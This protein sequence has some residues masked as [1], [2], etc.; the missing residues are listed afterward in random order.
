TFGKLLTPEEIFYYIYAVLY[1]NVY[2]TKYAEFL[3]IDFPRIPFTSDYDIFA[4]MS[5]LGKRLTDLHLLKSPELDS[6]VAKFQGSG[7]SE[8]V[9]V[10]FVEN[11]NRVYI[12]ETQYFEGISKEVFEYQIGGYEV[13]SKWLKDRKGRYLTLDETIT[14]C[15][16]ATALFRTIAIQQEIDIL[17]PSCEKTLL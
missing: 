16:I 6:P 14:Y 2:R 5:A 3:K 7:N 1:S 10:N 4:K 11:E 17:Y 8:V 9:K 13:L 12:N 15:K